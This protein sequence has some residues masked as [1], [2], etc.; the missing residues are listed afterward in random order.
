MNDRAVH[1]GQAAAL[2]GLAPSTVRWWE[3][4]GVLDPPARDGG[5][6]VYTDADLR[7][8]GVAYLCC[9]VGKMPLDQA[10]VV[11]SGKAPHGTWQRAVGDQIE[12][13][14]QRIEQLEAARDYLR[15]LL[16]CHDDDMA[17]CRF[18]AGELSART[19][20]G[21]VA[22]VDLV[23]AA[24]AAGKGRDENH[25]SDDEKP[26]T[27]AMCAGPIARGK[28]GRRRKYCSP[29]CRQQAYRTRRK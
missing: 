29:A 16:S 1:I 18:L 9:V 17:Q 10:A 22:D 24:R 20:R 5:K 28:R 7:R 25:A 27:C 23:A 21:S 26:E 6:R 14:G 8:I 13:M 15:H 4:Q 12:S 19:P 3:S 2:Y 11:T